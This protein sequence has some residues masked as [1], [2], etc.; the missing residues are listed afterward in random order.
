[1]SAVF[2]RLAVPLIL[3]ALPSGT[4]AQSRDAEHYELLLNRDGHI[5]GLALVN[6]NIAVNA[7]GGF[8]NLA[9]DVTVTDGHAMAADTVRVQ[10][11]ARAFDVFANTLLAGRDSTIAG[12]VTSILPPIFD[13]EPLVVPDPFDPANFPPNFPIP[14]GGPD[15][16]GGMHETFTLL[17]GAYGPVA[18]G[19]LGKLILQ[20]G[21]YQ[22]CSLAAPHIGDIV[23]NAPATID[24]AGPLLVGSLST[25]LPVGSPAL[26]EINVMGPIVRIGSGSIFN[27]R[28]FAPFLDRDHLLT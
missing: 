22:F 21:H 10:V 6:G 13:S 15:R 18:V 24:V 28:L 27:A 19:A 12:T 26:V 2:L 16:A 7:P 8:L 14:C 20:P 17:P 4:A 1:M 3:V 5:K 23:V 25:L 11:R 9:H